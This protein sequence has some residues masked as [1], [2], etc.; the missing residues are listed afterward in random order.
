MMRLNIVYSDRLTDA[1]VQLVAHNASRNL[2]RVEGVINIVIVE[3]QVIIPPIYGH[4]SF[5][6]IGRYKKII[7]FI[8]NTILNKEVE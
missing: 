5:I 3:N 6:E 2:S 1:L 8:Y 4:C 7:K